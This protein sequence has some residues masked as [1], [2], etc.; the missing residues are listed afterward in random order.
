LLKYLP[1]FSLG[2]ESFRAKYVG[3][4]VK[5][6]RY[7]RQRAGGQQAGSQFALSNLELTFKDKNGDQLADSHNIPNR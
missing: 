5:I 4:N 1:S 6:M 3:K 2:C 7:E